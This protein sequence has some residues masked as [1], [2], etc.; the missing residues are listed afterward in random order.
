[1]KVDKLQWYFDYPILCDILIVC[2]GVILTFIFKNQIGQIFDYPSS[3]ELDG[4]G[5][6][7]LTV[8]ATLI[9]FLLTIITVI[10]TF[11]N[12]FSQQVL[13]DKSEEVID[14][15]EGIP[16]D[17]VFDKS[18]SK[19]EQFYDSDLYKYVVHVL[20]SSVIELGVLSF[21]VLVVKFGIIDLSI[22]VLSYFYLSIFMIL[23]LA[24]FRS[25]ILFKYYLKVHTPDV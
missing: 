5:T 23:S 16:I 10:V 14:E 22:F 4:F 7:I 20:I 6:L 17:T 13:Q 2:L 11:R 18:L 9:G 15:N 25:F 12:G 24:V 8:S 21:G 19:E 1:M 3:V